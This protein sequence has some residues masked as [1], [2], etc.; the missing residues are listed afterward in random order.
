MAKICS[1]GVFA[2]PPEPSAQDPPW[3]GLRSFGNSGMQQS[4]EFEG[5]KIE[6]S[7][8]FFFSLL[9]HICFAFYTLSGFKEVYFDPNCKIPY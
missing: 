2:P 9:Y 4:V 3:I 1:A 6:F 7:M 5:T 8:V